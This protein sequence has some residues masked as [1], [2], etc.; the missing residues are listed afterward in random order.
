MPHFY[1]DLH[2]D[3]DLPDPTG[4]E[5]PDLA[6]ARNVAIGLI[7]SIL[8]RDDVHAASGTDWRLDVTD[9]RGFVLA[10]FHVETGA[11]PVPDGDPASWRTAGLRPSGAAV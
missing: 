8:A 4:V 10:W 9:E 3:R 5:L 7:S 1:F 6:A 2:D 11:G